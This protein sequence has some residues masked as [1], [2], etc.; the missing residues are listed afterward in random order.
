MHDQ[1]WINAPKEKSIT[2]F[3]SSVYPKLESIYLI[4][5][6]L[7]ELIQTHLIFSLAFDITAFYE[8]IQTKF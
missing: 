8:L 4:I 6:T 5:L 7:C 3:F 1:P 2:I